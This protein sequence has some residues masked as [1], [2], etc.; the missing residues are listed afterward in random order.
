MSGA[1][2]A[3][4][5]PKQTTEV[6]P[7]L[8]PRYKVLLHNDDVTTAD[9][10]VYVLIE[11]FKKSLQEAVDLMATAHTTGIALVTVLPLEEA[12]L[13]AQ[14]AHALARTQKFPLMFTYEPE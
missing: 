12:E 1:Q 9:F 4:V 8:T 6:T 10:V 2:P 3:I 7:R 14:Q 11:V 13:R 5:E